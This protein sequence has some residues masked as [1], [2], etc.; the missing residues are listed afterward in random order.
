M[1][2]TNLKPLFEYLDEKFGF[3]DG[4][5]D[6]IDKRLNNLETSVDNLTKIVKDFQEEHIILHRRVETLEAWAKK[7]SEKIGIPLPF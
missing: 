5:F 1:S 6:G 2:E 3:M 7:V 4:R